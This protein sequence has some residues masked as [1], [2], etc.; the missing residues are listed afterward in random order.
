MKTPDEI[1][2]ELLARY[3]QLS[4]CAA[5]LREAYQC[6]VACYEHDGILY[7][8]GNGGSCADSDHITGE[9]LKGF[10]SRRPLPAEECEKL[11][12]LAGDDGAMLA[13]TLQCGLRAISLNSHAA[14]TTAVGNDL[15]DNLGP[16]QMLQALGRPGDVF[17][18]ISTSGNARNLALA[19]AV[20]KAKEVKVIGL[21]GRNGGKL[22]QSAD[23][24]ICVPED[25]TYKIQELHLPVYHALC[26]MLE[27][28]F[29]A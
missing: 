7:V 11:Q 6:L 5:S 13:S 29:F 2:S 21:T 28:R 9:L 18:A 22:R 14:L 12:S 26:L 17:L 19:G 10:V 15:G 23:I 4:T 3:P 24:C 8:C 20:A 27:S 1:L 25:E 16:A